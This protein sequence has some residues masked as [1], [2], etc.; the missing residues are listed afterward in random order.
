MRADTAGSG[1][2]DPPKRVL[3]NFSF[4]GTPNGATLKLSTSLGGS[5]WTD[6]SAVHT[7]YEYTLNFDIL[8]GINAVIADCGWS[9]EAGSWYQ[10]VG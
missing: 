2:P 9:D 8:C 5:S 1:Q 3:G 4:S 10:K 7:E 6:P